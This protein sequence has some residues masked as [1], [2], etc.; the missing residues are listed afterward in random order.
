[1]AADEGK[2]EK[3]KEQKL[4]WKKNTVLYLH[5]LCY[6]LAAV[7]VLFLLLFRLIIVSG[8]SM[9][10]TLIDGDYLLL[11]SHMVYP[12]PKQ[13][14]IVVASKE[15]FEN[16]EPIIKRVIAT[17]GQIVDIDFANGI[18]YVDGLP[19]E[20]EYIKAPTTVAEG[21]TF[22]LMVE[23]GCIFVMGD[24]RQNSK[25]SR[26]PEIGLVD[27]REVLGKAIFL[28]LPG[29]S[30]GVRDYGRIGVVQ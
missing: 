1:M 24:N 27:T 28:F 10:D 22:P 5:D 7:F 18:V 26:D 23:D 6:L 29:A 2:K 4:G 25:D 21:M 12:N 30:E 16:G 3:K 15:S 20:E 17:E 13:G 14:D 11:M 19:L 8:G 9:N